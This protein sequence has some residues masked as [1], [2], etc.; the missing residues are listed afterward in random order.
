MK[1]ITQAQALFLILLVCLIAW[2]TAVECRQLCKG[3]WRL[4]DNYPAGFSGWGKI[5]RLSENQIVIDDVLFPLAVNAT[6]NVPSVSGVPAS[7]FEAGHRVGY[8]LNS[9][10]QIMSLWKIPE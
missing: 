10:G 7:W 9:E 6:F 5:D 1:K 2:S 8:V 4:P 3:E